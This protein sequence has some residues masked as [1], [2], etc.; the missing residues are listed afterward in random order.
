M[1]KDVVSIL[2]CPSCRANKLK[3]EVFD[4][5]SYGVKEGVVKCPRCTRT[6]PI[7]DYI[8][9]L[10]PDDLAYWEDRKIFYKR[11]KKRFKLEKE[12]QQYFDW[13]AKNSTQSYSDYA[14][15]SFWRATDELIIGKWRK[16]IRKDSWLLDVGCAQGRSAFQFADLPIS[17]VGFDIS[18][19][20]IVEAIKRSRGRANMYFFVGDATS[21]PIKS[22]SFDYVLL[23]GVL[24]HLPDPRKTVKEIIR[25]LKP[26]GTYFGLENNKTPVRIFFDFLQ[27]LHPL[28]YERAGSMPLIG[29]R[30]IKGWFNGQHKISVS[31]HTFLPPHIVNLFSVEVAK[32]MLSKTDVIAKFMPD[33]GGLINIV[34]ERM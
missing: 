29:K 7:F 27:K 16:G 25:V 23:Y 6:Y 1:N 13:Y 11:H 5:D 34:M 19:N 4:K 30:D 15:S 20:M 24:H 28:W 21:F 31:T 8:L 32:R 22:E 3:L 17:I 26:G 10:L 2:L 12:Q 33:A 9:E 14:G 18:K